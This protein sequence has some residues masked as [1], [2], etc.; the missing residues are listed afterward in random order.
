MSIAAAGK[1]LA[2]AG[3]TPDQVGCVIVLDGHHLYQTPS[4]AAEVAYKLGTD[5][6]RRSTSRSLRRL[7]LRA[8]ARRRHGS[9]WHCGTRPR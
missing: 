6:R 9:R 8:L 2:H 1:A 5:G 4:A 3:L 7:L